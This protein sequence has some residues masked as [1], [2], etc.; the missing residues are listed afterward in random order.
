[1]KREIYLIRH[2]ET[3]WNKER[4]F[5]GQTD[6]PLNDNGRRQAKSLRESLKG[7]RL[8]GHERTGENLAVCTYSGGARILV[9]AG[10]EDARIA[11]EPVPARS[12]RVLPG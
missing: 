2:G 8:C 6:I 1:M 9:N 7:Q 10:D 5:Q 12:Y 11:G 3:D 4:R